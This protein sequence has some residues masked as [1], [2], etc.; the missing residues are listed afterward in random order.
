MQR[1]VS[2]QAAAVGPARDALTNEAGTSKQ[3]GGTPT[4]LDAYAAA[5][6]GEV[7]K[8]YAQANPAAKLNLAIV[9]A[10][11]AEASET[12][13]LRQVATTIISDDYQ[14]AVLWGMRAAK[15]T[16]PSIVKS[17]ILAND[18][19]LR[20]AI[21]LAVKKHTKGVLAGDIAREAYESLV[22]Q[23]EF[24]NRRPISPAMVAGVVPYLHQLMRFRLEEYKGG[25]STL[26]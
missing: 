23:P 20:K 10:R 19:A 3:P 8:V 17:P 11:V 7:Q 5:I 9:V 1:I 2:G 6:N 24:D 4:F 25:I 14:P 16:V 26:R 18:T 15:W 21:P 12:S 13:Q 22:L